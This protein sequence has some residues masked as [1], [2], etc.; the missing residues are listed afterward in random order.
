MGFLNKTP[1]DTYK[2]LIQLDNSGAGL[3]ASPKQM[4]DGGGKN[5]PITV[6]RNSVG[7]QP[8]A[9][10]DPEAFY[11]KNKDGSK[12]L[13]NIDSTT[14]IVSFDSHDIGWHGSSARVKIFPSDFIPNDDSTTFNL[15]VEDDVATYGLRATSTS[16][17]MYAYIPIPTDFKATHVQVYDDSDNR[18]VNVYEGFI[19]GTSA[20]S[21]GSG[22]C[23]TEI[24]ITDVISSTTN[25]LI[26]KVTTTST[27]DVVFGGYVTIAKL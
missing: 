26:V 4:K 9:A 27:T 18:T 15:A 5:I 11:V 13:I 7:F 1:K 22:V 12:K 2:D 25:Y 16:L 20:V 19:D 14:N 6:G 24:N 17:E 10:D 3:P 21:K 8:T 23:N